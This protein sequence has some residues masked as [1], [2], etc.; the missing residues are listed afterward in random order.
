MKHLTSKQL[1]EEWINF[2]ESK[3]HL[4]VESKSLIPVDDPSLLWIN[5][6]VATLKDFFSG[7]KQPPSKRLVNSQ[8]AIRTNDI[9][10]VG[11]TSRHHTMFEM[12]G[13]FSIGDY[14]KAEA[15][16]F[17]WEFLT[18]TLE[19]EPQLLYITYF[20]EDKD[21]YNKWIEIGVSPSNLIAGDRD[22][23]FWDMGV[24]PCGPDTEIFF[25]RGEKYDKRG[26]E[27]VENDIDNDRYIEIWNI[28]FSEF[29]NDGKGNYSELSQKN[30]D[31]G[32][33]LERLGSILQG[34]HT[35]FDT[36]LFLTIIK[37]I[38]EITGQEYDGNNYFKNDPKQTKINKAFKVISD[39]MRAIVNAIAD[40][41]KPSNV[42]RGYIIRRLIRRAY[43]SG[44]YLGV[45]SKAFLYT[46]TQTVKDSLPFDVDVEAVSSIIRKEE[47]AFA[48]TIH[49]GEMLLEKSIVKGQPFDFSIAFKLFETYGFP[50]ELTQEI[51][52]ER[53]IE[54]DISKFDEYRKKHADAS[55]GK[56]AQ[57]MQKQMTSLS[58]ISGL[59][60]EF[61]GY[62]TEMDY[63]EAL[64]FLNET[65]ELEEIDGEGYVVFAQTPFY[66]TSGG[67]RYDKG[68]IKQNNNSA[69]VLDVFK[70]KFGN[71]IH[72]VKGKLVKGTAVLSVDHDVRNG[73]MRNHSGTHL[74]FKALREVFGSDT[75]EQL[76]SDNNE[77]R[78][79]FDFPSDKKPSAEQMQ[80]VEKLVNDYIALD[81]IRNYIVTD[82]KSAEAM[83]AIMT[84]GED[85]YSSKVRVVEFPGIT[86]DLCG[87]THIPSTGGIESFLIT[88][89]ENKGSGVFRLEAITSKKTVHEWTNARMKEYTKDIEKAIK[90]NKA[91]DSTYSFNKTP[92]TIA[93]AMQNIKQLRE[94]NKKLAKQAK[95]IEL[96]DVKLEKDFFIKLDARPD[97]IKTMAISLRE[98]HPKGTFVVGATTDK[99]LI[100]IASK[101]KDCNQLLQLINS[102]LNG[103]GGGSKDFAQGVCDNDNAQSVIKEVLNG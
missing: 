84:V 46:L 8:K 3:G 64:I 83:G 73:L 24:G 30:I 99:L 10:N 71:H 65:E 95:K 77:E 100:A 62:E 40:G 12:L 61:T 31:T 29:N 102:K 52:S 32:A 60:S 90:K 96:P 47:L 85:T 58:K 14:F 98:K 69:E 34:G 54:L 72:K 45:K 97:Q 7:K 6:G 16:E 103:R 21:T 74:V 51:L 19:I 101:E 33:G 18:K 63:S 57:A 89:V 20:T 78:L 48:E 94:D 5:S 23:N 50:I 70:D 66:A 56:V 22:M 75:I 49:N 59:I 27:L 9:E 86:S 44:L 28:V 39:H 67:Q 93:D 87:G 38:E 92:K 2:F 55:R 80:K 42:S 53:G 68:S 17:A 81:V 15:I 41:A 26:I 37:K 79:R 4:K 88:S 91:L 13:N 25:D 82:L 36:D 76:G 11:V 43:R 1:R 35:N